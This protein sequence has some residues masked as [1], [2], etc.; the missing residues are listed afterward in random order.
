[1]LDYAVGGFQIMVAQM[2]VDVQAVLQRSCIVCVATPGLFQ[3][4]LEALDPARRRRRWWV[5]DDQDEEEEMS[6]WCCMLIT[7]DR[8]AS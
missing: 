1:L 7:H 2:G 8:V 6:R 4:F 5:V 3:P